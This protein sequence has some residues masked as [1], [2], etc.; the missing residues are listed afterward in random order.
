MGMIATHLKRPGHDPLHLARLRGLLATS[1]VANGKTTEAL[2]A[3][4]ASLPE[5]LRRDQDDEAGENA[6]YWRA[7]WQ[8]AILEEY[9]DLLA[10]LHGEGRG[11]TEL[12]PV[13]ES[14]RI[15]DIARGSNVQEAI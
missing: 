9:L 5:L 15:A 6:G 8:R 1:L 12:D 10:R 13:Q 3:F 4:Q 7:F 2:S 14:F 11:G